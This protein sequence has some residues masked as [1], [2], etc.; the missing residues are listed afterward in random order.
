MRNRLL[1]ALV[2]ASVVTAA[3]E[4]G[5]QNATPREAPPGN[6]TVNSTLNGS[7]VGTTPNRAA[8]YTTN[9]GWIDND[10]MRAYIDARN[11]CAAQL[12]DRQAAC[13]NRANERFPSVDS[14]C[15]KLSGSAL[16]DCLH[17]AD[18]GG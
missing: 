12:P 9:S 7:P 15:Q 11:A 10:Q 3:A 14:K 1:V 4:V 2:A 8:D 16:D 6:P 13:D 18:H 17:G 5:A